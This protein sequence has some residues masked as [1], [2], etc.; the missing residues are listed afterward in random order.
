MIKIPNNNN[1]KEIMIKNKKWISDNQS[2]SSM[3]VH[4]G[5]TTTISPDRDRIPRNNLKKKLSEISIPG[6]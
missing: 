6:N 2:V 4:G 3:S 5:S 1:Q